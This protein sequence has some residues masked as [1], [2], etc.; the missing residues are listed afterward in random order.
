MTIKTRQISLFFLMLAC[1]ATLAVISY[2]HLRGEWILYRQ[3]KVLLQK[4]DY[5]GAIPFFAAS[6]EKKIS[7]PQVLADL[8]LA[9]LAIGRFSQATEAYRAYLDRRPQDRQARIQL[10]RALSWSGR[11]DEAIVEYRTFLG[12]DP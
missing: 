7:T 5:Q 12:A 11:Y 4:E 9:Y 10:A 8:G 2:H 1:T 3:G 6:L